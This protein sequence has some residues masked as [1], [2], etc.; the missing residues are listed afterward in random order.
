MAGQKTGF[1]L[2]QRDNRRLVREVA[3]GRRVLNAFCYSGGFTLAALAGG[4]LHTTSLDSSADALALGRANLA[5][6]PGLDAAANT[7]LE[8]D[9]FADLRRMRNEAGAF[10]L[11]VL[12]PPK[13]APTAAHA[14]A[15]RAPYKDI[16]LLALKLLTRGG[17]L[18]TFSCSGGISA[19]LFQKIVAGAALDAGAGCADPAPAGRGRRPSGGLELPGRRLPEGL[20]PPQELIWAI[21]TKNKAAPVA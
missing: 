19:D 21:D 7:W 3:G 1:Y 9:V 18:A 15:P 13:F 10:D 20:A 6:N 12:D 17:L 11:I 8:A 14:S 2:D 16:N 4:A 5:L